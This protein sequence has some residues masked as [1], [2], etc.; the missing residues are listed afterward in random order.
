LRCANSIVFSND[1][2]RSQDTARPE[3]SRADRISEPTRQAHT[4]R[5]TYDR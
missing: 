3:K 2:K 4:L 1:A 5:P